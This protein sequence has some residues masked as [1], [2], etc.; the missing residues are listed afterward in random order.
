MDNDSKIKENVQLFLYDELSAL[1]KNM[2]T[3]AYDIEKEYAAT[4]KNRSYFIPVTLGICFLAVALAITGAFLYINHRDSSIQV[5]SS[6]FDDVDSRGF[7]DSVYRLRTACENAEGKAAALQKE[8]EDALSEAQKQLEFDLYV[9]QSMNLEKQSE[10]NTRTAAARAKHRQNVKDLHARYD[11][12]ISAAQ[13]E[14]DE[15]RARLGRFD[16]SAVAEA[17]KGGAVSSERQLQQMEIDRISGDYEARIASLRSDMRDA[18][19]RNMADKT[20]AVREV[21]EKYQKEI[22]ALD[23][24]IEDDLAD[25]IIGEASSLSR[26]QFASADYISAAP[27]SALGGG[28][29]TA[30]ET[31]QKNYE[32]S[33]YLYKKIAAVP[34]KHSMP[35]YIASDRLLLLDS[36]RQIAAAA[37]SRAGALY[38]KNTELSGER[39]LLETALAAVIASAGEKAVVLSAG[40]R[41]AALYVSADARDQIRQEPVPAVLADAKLRIKG[42]V[43]Y[44]GGSFYFIPAPPE[45][46]SKQAAVSLAAV[47]PGSFVRLTAK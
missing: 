37:V 32:D 16:Q 7:M 25:S 29:V 13:S 10:I 46:D 4:K 23:P 17:E 21:S 11:A 34:Q 47:A 33:E 8:L 44:D 9:V 5:S 18:N 39:D 45:K 41:R 42:T 28:L 3:S 36:G 40:E 15:Y 20:A 14:A 26:I 35:S 24:V 30:L 12:A 31:A 1:N 22:A 2:R 43:Q 27:S 19:Q 38:E 6:V